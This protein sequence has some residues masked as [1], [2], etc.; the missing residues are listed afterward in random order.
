M[1]RLTSD[2]C[3]IAGLVTMALRLEGQPC[4]TAPSPLHHCTITA[5]SLYHYCCI[6]APLLLHH[7]TITAASLHHHYCTI[8]AAPS[9]LHHY[10]ITAAPLHH[11]CCTTAPSLLYHGTII[12]VPIYRQCCTTA[13]AAALPWCTPRHYCFTT[14]LLLLILYQFNTSSVLSVYIYMWMCTIESYLIIL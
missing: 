10:T 13:A 5:A 7:C 2:Q 9:L 12:D 4:T 14:A 11:H 1:D 8:T 6:T 3:V